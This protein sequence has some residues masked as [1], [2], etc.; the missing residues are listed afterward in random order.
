MPTYH[1]T[2]RAHYNDDP[3]PCSGPAAVTILLADRIHG[4]VACEQHGADRM[5]EAPGS[6]PIDLPDAP[7]RAGMRV[8]QAAGGYQ[9]P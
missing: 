2:C 6:Y 7:S 8:W 3:Q 5:R 4:M 9:T 1:P